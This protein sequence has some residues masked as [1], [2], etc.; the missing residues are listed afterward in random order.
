MPRYRKRPVEIDAVQL[1]WTQWSE[2]CEFLG[3]ALTAENSDGAWEIPAAEASD[4]C[5]EEGPNYIALNVRTA[6]GEIAI[7]RHGDWIIPEKEPGRFYPCKP[8][9]FAATYEEVTA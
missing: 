7:V 3:D 9:V 1:R 6:H 2:V 5:G 8:D 4:T